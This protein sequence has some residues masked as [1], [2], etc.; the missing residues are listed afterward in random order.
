MSQFVKLYI[1][2]FVACRIWLD[3]DA[4]AGA[5]LAASMEERIST[6]IVIFDRTYQVWAFLLEHCEPTGQSTYTAA[7]RQK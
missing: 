6:N 2:Q 5:I 4:H 3:E 7:L 1:S